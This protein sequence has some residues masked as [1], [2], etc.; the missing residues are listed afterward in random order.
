MNPTNKL[1][2]HHYHQHCN[3]SHHDNVQTRDAIINQLCFVVNGCLQCNHHHIEINNVIVMF[4]IVVIVI[5]VIIVVIIQAGY[6]VPNK[7]CFAVN[8]CLRPH[9]YPCTNSLVII[10]VMIITIMNICV[11]NLTMIKVMMIL[12]VAKIMMAMIK[13]TPQ[14][15]FYQLP[16]NYHDNFDHSEDCSDH[17][18]YFYHKKSHDDFVYDIDLKDFNHDEEHNDVPS[19]IYT[20]TLLGITWIQN[21]LLYPATFMIHSLSRCLRFDEYE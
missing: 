20:S 2:Q 12:I 17:E 10:M 11:N 14:V 9:Y 15:S 21:G 18:N 8:G 16:G 19:G 1:L 3:H 5:V 4:I 13:I 6:A 7:L